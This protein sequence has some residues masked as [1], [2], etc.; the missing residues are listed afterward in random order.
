MKVDAKINVKKHF[1]H[2]LIGN[3]KGHLEI[4]S[5]YCESD[6]LCLKLKLW[7]KNYD[8]EIILRHNS[9]TGPEWKYSSVIVVT[10]HDHNYLFTLEENEK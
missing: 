1:L 6:I 10:S 2:T 7:N 8:Q 3:W 4:E 9:L 5:E